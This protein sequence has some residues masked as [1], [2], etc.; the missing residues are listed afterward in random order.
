MTMHGAVTTPVEDA[1]C[2]IERT[3]GIV[4]ERWTFLILREALTA[5]STKFAEFTD[6]LGIAPNILTDRLKTLTD[7]GVL[8]KRE[9]QVPGSR[10]RMSYHPTEAGKQLLV[11]LGAL[12]QWGDDYVPPRSGVTQLRE[13]K[14]GHKPVRVGF[15]TDVKALK[16]VEDIE[17]VRT[18]SH[19]KGPSPVSR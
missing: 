10:P 19:P 9:Y 6:V 15:V 11:V 2:S 13:V 12:Q 17:V 4:G 7:S 14:R 16:N 3:L 8:E 18:A 1:F 5:G